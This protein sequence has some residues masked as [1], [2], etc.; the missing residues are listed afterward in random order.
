MVYLGVC[1]GLCIGIGLWVPSGSLAVRTRR[2]DL[3]RCGDAAMVADGKI[4]GIQLKADPRSLLRYIHLLD[5]F[6][7]DDVQ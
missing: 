6:L 3:G 4:Y 1:G 2:S 7:L 5:S